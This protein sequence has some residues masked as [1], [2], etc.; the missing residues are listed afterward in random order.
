MPHKKLFFDETL[1]RLVDWD[2]ILEATKEARTSYL[3]MPL[4]NYCNKNSSSRIST[5]VYQGAGI[6]EKIQSIQAKY[7]YTLDEVQNIDVRLDNFIR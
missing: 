7:C 6:I 3:P 4:V 2:Y 1:E 5:T